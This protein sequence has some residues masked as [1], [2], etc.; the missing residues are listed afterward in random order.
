[1]IVIQRSIF[2]RTDS[3]ARIF[4]KFL[5]KGLAVLVQQRSLA[6]GSRCLDA[7]LGPVRQRMGRFKLYYS[8]F[9]ASATD[10]SSF[11]VDEPSFFASVHESMK[12]WR[13]LPIL[14]SVLISSIRCIAGPGT[15]RA[16][17]PSTGCSL[18]ST[19]AAWKFRFTFAIVVLFVLEKLPLIVIKLFIVVEVINFVVIPG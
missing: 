3:V 17:S 10:H 2:E 6:L 7:N 14:K 9:N 8:V 13:T 4:H 16:L 12:A 5:A 11:S 15:G 18:T 19:F 1:M